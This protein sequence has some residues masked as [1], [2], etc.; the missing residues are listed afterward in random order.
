MKISLVV[1]TVGENTVFFRTASASHVYKDNRGLL[2]EPI[3]QLA[4]TVTVQQNTFILLN[5]NKISLH[6]NTLYSSVHF[7]H[8]VTQSNI[9]WDSIFLDSVWAV[10]M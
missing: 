10:Q 2:R 4:L 1:M 8:P 6:K 5:E 3:N 9:C 7:S